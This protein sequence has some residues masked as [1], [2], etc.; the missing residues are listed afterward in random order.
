MPTAKDVDDLRMHASKFEWRLEREIADLREENAKL[1]KDLEQ[2]TREHDRKIE[3]LLDE[4]AK[5]KR[6]LS[7]ATYKRD[8][9]EQERD[10]LREE[11][12]RAALTTEE[13]G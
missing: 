1:K 11:R 8:Q 5:L 3:E 2:A 13:I 7:W 12:G 10:E 6:D 9:I 4:N